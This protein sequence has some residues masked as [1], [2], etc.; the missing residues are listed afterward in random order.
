MKKSIISLTSALFF[1]VGLSM[2]SAAPVSAAVDL[3]A[4]TPGT[5][6]F[7]KELVMV[8][9]ATFTDLINTANA[10][11]VVKPLNATVLL[12]FSVAAGS[13]K[14][15]RF[16]LSGGATFQTLPVL[17]GILNN[18]SQGGL[19]FG[20]VIFEINAGGATVPPTTPLVLQ[21][22]TYRVVSNS[23]TVNMTYHLY[24][25]ASDAVNNVVANAL[26][27]KENVPFINY[28]SGMV[29]T[30]TPVV[31]EKIDAVTGSLTFATQMAAVGD[32]LHTLLGDVTIGVNTSARVPSTGLLLT[33]A[34]INTLVGTD[35]NLQITGDFSAVAPNGVY[36][37]TDG[38]AT[39]T[40][41][42]TMNVAKTLATFVLGQNPLNGTASSVSPATQ[43]CFN[44]T[45]TIEIK[46]GDYKAFYD[47]GATGSL[48][49]YAADW[50]ST[51]SPGTIISSLSK[52]SK[53]LQSPWFS[54]YTNGA[55]TRFLITNMGN[56]AVDFGVK[57]YTEPGA[58]G[59]VNLV[60]GK[61]TIPA[62]SM[63]VYDATQLIT[64]TGQTRASIVF[65][66]YG[67]ASTIQ[68]AFQYYNLTTGLM[69]TVTMTQPNA[70]YT[71]TDI[72]NSISGVKTVVDTINTNNP[73][74]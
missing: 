60:N 65:E 56:N 32:Y 40:P 19:G 62:N 38:C 28:A 30:F 37:S 24:T 9:P 55:T 72:M 49:T 45:G 73:G 18:Y 47:T 44:V 43:I 25:S 22:D 3:D 46:V 34:T 20:F 16:D 5:Q 51:G 57:V 61:G 67:V 23:A 21:G 2:T 11:P 14:Y 1:A 36:L 6:T 59:V 52:N 10:D 70:D 8:S 53:A 50:P 7:V 69:S 29:E 48:G 74:I 27:S 35:A 31:T 64:L 63:K 39:G 68:G 41:A 71:P 12:G 17:T 26:K 42:T 4:A 15:V 33:S 13:T 58:T 54:T 66:F